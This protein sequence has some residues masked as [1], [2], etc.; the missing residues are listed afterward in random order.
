[1]SIRDDWRREVEIMKHDG[2]EQC[3]EGD[4]LDA[5]GLYNCDPTKET[6]L[7]VNTL[8]GAYW[9]CATAAIL[10]KLQK[11]VEIVINDEERRKVAKDLRETSELWRET[12]PDA[13]TEEETFGAAIM[14]D[15]LMFVGLDYES[16]VHAIY[17]HLAD[18]IEPQ[19]IDGNTSDGYHTFN[20]LYHHRAV[21]FSVIVSSFSDRAWKSKLHA[22]GTMYDG[23]FIVG[24]ETPDG[25]ATY[26]YDVEPYWNL[27]RCKEVDRAPEWDGHTPDQAIERIGKFADCKTDRPTCKMTECG[28]DHGSRSWGMRCSACGAE[29]EH[30]K[31]IYGWAFCPKCGAEV[32]DDD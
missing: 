24:I 18:L 15:L 19:P 27:F 17:A 21:L 26:H 11:G 12:F 3:D 30:V 22:D 25:Q 2:D 20:E 8:N 29:F 13:T 32:V 1:M 16:P 9:R 7:L 31:P 14:S 23:M 5:L 28:I 4:A 6:V 10:R